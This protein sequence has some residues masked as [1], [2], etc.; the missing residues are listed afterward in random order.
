M[1]TEVISRTLVPGDNDEPPM[2]TQ[3]EN[4]RH[5]RDTFDIALG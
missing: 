4:P 5:I 2:R 3:H 1:T